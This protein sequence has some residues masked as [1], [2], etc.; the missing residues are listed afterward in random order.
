MGVMTTPSRS[1]EATGWINKPAGNCDKHQREHRASSVSPDRGPGPVLSA[2]PASPAPPRFLPTPLQPGSK[3]GG[4]CSYHPPAVP[5]TCNALLPGL[6]GWCRPVLGTGLLS[7]VVCDS[8]PLL[9]LLPSPSAKHVSPLFRLQSVSC[10]R[11]WV[12]GGL[13]LLLFCSLLLFWCP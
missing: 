4:R 6:P 12:P 7:Y 3:P 10:A 5:S 13:D 9:P 8:P 11:T 1:S 2:S